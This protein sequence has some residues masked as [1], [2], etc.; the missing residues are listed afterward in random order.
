MKD[1]TRTNALTHSEKK[2]EKLNE[3]L[4]DY[5]NDNPIDNSTSKQKD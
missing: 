5:K 1:V 4:D 2:T 3:I